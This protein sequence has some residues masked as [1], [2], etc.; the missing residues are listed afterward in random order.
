MNIFNN[1]FSDY[2]VVKRKYTVKLNKILEFWE[3]IR[4]LFQIKKFFYLFKY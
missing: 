2:Y 1:Y 3:K 4:L